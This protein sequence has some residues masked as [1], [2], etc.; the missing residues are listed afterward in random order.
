MTRFAEM[1]AATNYS[2]LRG[3]SRPQDMVLT[4]LIV[5]PSDAL[6]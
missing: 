2:F 3:A 1:A 6:T 5:P 4:A